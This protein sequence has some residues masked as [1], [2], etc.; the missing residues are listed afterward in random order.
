MPQ[1]Q[2]DFRQRVGAMRNIPPFLREIWSTSK[3]LTILSIGIRLV[4]AF[5]PIA[6]LYIGKLII[7]EAI[8]LIGADVP[9]DL[10]DAWSAGQLNHLSPCSASNSGLRLSPTSQDAWC[11]TST[12]CCQSNSPMPPP[13]A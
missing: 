10:K 13:S 5:L 4:R 12:R 1:Q 9:H 7:D 8:R 11:P 2:L 6:T 3:T